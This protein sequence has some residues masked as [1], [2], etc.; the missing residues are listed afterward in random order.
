MFLSLSFATSTWTPASVEQ[1]QQVATAAVEEFDHQ[2]HVV[3]RRR[4]VLGL[5]HQKGNWDLV[6]FLC[7]LY[8]HILPGL[9]TV[10]G[11]GCSPPDTQNSAEFPR[12]AGCYFAGFDDQKEYFLR[13]VFDRLDESQGELE[14]TSR[15]LEAED[16]WRLL[17]NICLLY[18]S[19]SPRDQR[20]SRMPSSA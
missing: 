5:D 14:W 17:S 13:R 7:R 19:P 10:L 3:F 12:F 9:K 8:S 6:I 20:G 2:A 1:L 16:N 4:D 18:T 15:S 11:N